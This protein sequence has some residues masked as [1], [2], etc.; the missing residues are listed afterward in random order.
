MIV[1]EPKTTACL[2][3]GRAAPGSKSPASST[4]VIALRY[5]LD[6]I[7]GRICHPQHIPSCRGLDYT[8]I[9]LA[10]YKTLRTGSEVAGAAS[11]S[12]P[13]SEAELRAPVPHQVWRSQALQHAPKAAPAAFHL[14]FFLPRFRVSAR[15]ATLASKLLQT[16][17]RGL[18]AQAVD[19]VLAPR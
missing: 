19:A 11:L 4:Q 13:L 2:E 10:P 18:L 16:T 17:H 6:D 5:V 14:Q 1:P 3:L 15:K 12:P 8:N 7:P 9:S